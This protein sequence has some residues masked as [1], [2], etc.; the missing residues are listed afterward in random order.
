MHKPSS[1]KEE[2]TAEDDSGDN[3]CPFA[4]HKISTEMST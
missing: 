2:N 1:G 4:R 3:A